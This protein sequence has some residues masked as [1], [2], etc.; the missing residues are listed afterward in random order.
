MTNMLEVMQ[1]AAMLVF[2][3]GMALLVI[4]YWMRQK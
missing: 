2:A 3:V 4:D 1:F